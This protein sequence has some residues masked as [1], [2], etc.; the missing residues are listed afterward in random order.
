VQFILHLGSLPGVY[1]KRGGCLKEDSLP[2]RTGDC[3]WSVAVGTPGIRDAGPS[4]SRPLRDQAEF[5]SPSQRGVYFVQH[6]FYFYFVCL[7]YF[8]CFIL[9]CFYFVH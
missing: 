3:L 1:K 2:G 9:F 4:R 8:I 5:I 7:F 6:L